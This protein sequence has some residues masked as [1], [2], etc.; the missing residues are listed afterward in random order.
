VR[1]HLG[2]AQL[3]SALEWGSRGRRFKSSHPDHENGFVIVFTRPFL[4]LSE[5]HS[6]KKHTKKHT[7]CPKLA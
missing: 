5:P 3:G 2:V 1:F 7:D 4:F 6:E